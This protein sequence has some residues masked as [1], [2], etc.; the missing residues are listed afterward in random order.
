MKTYIKLNF[1]IERKG[2]TTPFIPLVNCNPNEC[3]IARSLTKLGETCRA[4]E[5]YKNDDIVICPLVT[6][7]SEIKFESEKI[8]KIEAQNYYA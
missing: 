1:E 3:R 7:N 5:A 2:I 6:M 4:L 8:R